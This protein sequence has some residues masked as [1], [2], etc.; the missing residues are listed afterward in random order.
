MKNHLKNYQLLVDLD[1]NFKKGQV[2][3]GT[4]LG[5]GVKDLIIYNNGMN[6]RQWV[7]FSQVKLVRKQKDRTI[8]LIGFPF[9]SHV[10]QAARP[11]RTFDLNTIY[12]NGCHTFF[13]EVSRNGR[14]KVMGYSYDLTPLL[15]SYVVKQ[16]DRWQ[17]YYAPNKTLLRRALYGTIQKIVEIK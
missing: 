5:A 10:D 12:D 4:I 15:K 16:Y 7:D 6:K 17:Q 8:T 3:T 13:N 14:A 1:N 2:V 11:V 9:V